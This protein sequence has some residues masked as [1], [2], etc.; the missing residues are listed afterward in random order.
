MRAQL[1]KYYYSLRNYI[2]KL[3]YHTDCVLIGEKETTGSIRCILSPLEATARQLH[4]SV[5]SYCQKL[6]KILVLDS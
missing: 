5:V 4:Q 1:G 2:V 3:K 6:S